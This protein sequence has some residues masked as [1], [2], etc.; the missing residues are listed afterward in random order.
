MTEHEPKIADERDQF[1]EE[2]AAT[3]AADGYLL[4]LARLREL[5][6]AR[7]REYEMSR[8]PAPL[9][10]TT[11]VGPW[12][13][14]VRAEALTPLRESFRKA[15]QLWARRRTP[16]LVR[17]VGGGG[18]MAG[19][20][21]LIHEYVSPITDAA[22]PFPNVLTTAVSGFGLGGG[23]LLA[24]TGVVAFLIPTK[25]QAHQRDNAW[26]DMVE[27]AAIRV[28]ERRRQLAGTATAPVSAA[29]V[30]RT[31]DDLLAEWAAYRLD[32]EA[33]YL[34]K[35]VL[36]DVT[37]T[38]ETTVAYET[39]LQD[40][41]AAVE[42]LHSTSTDAQVSAASA[43]ADRAWQAWH[44]ANDYAAR[45]GLGDRTP[46]ERAALQRLS[47]LVTRL[48]HSAADDPELSAI[49]RDI[50]TCLD[51]VTTVA[52]GWN[53]IAALPAVERAQLLPQLTPT[54]ARS[55]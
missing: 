2:I 4:E 28:M 16:A 38:V 43:L 27:Q 13:D 48:T 45:V 49:K 42:N 29:D 26:S 47:K 22:G 20:S 25:W 32:V 17:G 9:A 52:V 19:S 5:N 51:K 21:V 23:A 31:L 12:R 39:A 53:D 41:I 50:Q 11:L 33:W 36:H 24:A 14:L 40:L 1:I 37:G 8:I 34:T 54:T 30:R 7:I 6:L 44:D 35:P 55:A 3:I 18:L 15:P 46:T 10:A